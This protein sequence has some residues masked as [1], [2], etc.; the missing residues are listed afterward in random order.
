MGALGSAGPGSGE[1]Y[2]K[3]EALG[4]RDASGAGLG[5]R[6]GTYL[7]IVYL[8]VGGT[9]SQVRATALALLQE[10]GEGPLH[11]PQQGRGCWVRLTLCRCQ[12]GGEW[13]PCIGHP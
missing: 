4:T 13:S 5:G 6:A 2:S 10:A 7:F 12:N 9:E 11:Q 3:G 1:G 8:Q